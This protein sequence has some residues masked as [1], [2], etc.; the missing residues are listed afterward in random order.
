MTEAEEIILAR[1]LLWQRE[2][3]RLTDAQSSRLV[4]M[5][6]QTQKEL[7]R[8]FDRMT[9]F[10]KARARNVL[11]Q[12]Q[13][14][15]AVLQQSAV[16]TVAQEA[17]KISAQAAECYSQILSFDGAATGVTG[18]SLSPVTMSAFLMDTPV[19]GGLLK[20]W[21]KKTFSTNG[22]ELL[23]EEIAKGILNGESYD[24]MSRRI[25]AGF[26]HSRR[27]MDTLVRTWMQSANNEALARIYAQNAD[28]VSQ[29]RWLATF[30]GGVGNGRGTCL[31][32]AARDGHVWPR[33]K[34]PHPPLH[35]RCRCVLIPHFDEQKAGL[36]AKDRES[37]RPY[38]V[39]EDGTKKPFASGRFSGTFDE[40][41]EKQPPHVAQN[42]LGRTRYE[43]WKNGGLKLAGLVSKDGK[44]IIPNDQLARRLKPGLLHQLSDATRRR[45][46]DPSW[47][48]KMETVADVKRIILERLTPVVGLKGKISNV[49]SVSLESGQYMATA[50]IVPGALFEIGLSSRLNDLRYTDEKGN[51]IRTRWQ[52]SET[53]RLA[54]LRIHQG[55]PLG[56]LEENALEGVYHELQHVKQRQG[57]PQ[58]DQYV[59]MEIVNEWTARRRYPEMLRELGVQPRY[60]EEIKKHGIGYTEGVARFDRIMARLGIKETEEFVDKLTAINEAIPVDAFLTPVANLLLKQATG[61]PLHYP[62][63][64]ILRNLHKQNFGNMLK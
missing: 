13:E 54:L 51:T 44:R 55:K 26:D 24:A 27:S 17:G 22:Q 4:R 40:W 16:E 20:T 48:G 35:P 49:R 62:L 47:L 41:L 34:A 25:R 45:V 5:I 8:R 23:R 2:L 11:K 3:N 37:A 10:Q 46:H 6:D 43:L 57:D 18:V 29:V 36:N 1:M 59:L 53:V 64:E 21:V 9:G 63:I 30:E 50:P 52:P 32:C 61:S 7:F 28:I 56:F 14:A 38:M 58:G 15:L 42:M 60:L 33:D 19:G 39:Y 12:T 31:L